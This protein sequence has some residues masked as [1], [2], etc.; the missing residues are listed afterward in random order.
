MEL[1]FAGCRLFAALG[2]LDP[3]AAVRWEGRQTNDNR[4]ELSGGLRDTVLVHVMH[5]YYIPATWSGDSGTACAG[6]GAPRSTTGGECATINSNTNT[7]VYQRLILL[8][9]T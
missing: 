5:S 2:R 3:W 8:Q 4:G 1:P 9:N 6:C 7:A